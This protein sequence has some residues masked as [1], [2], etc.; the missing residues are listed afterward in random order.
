MARGKYRKKKLVAKKTQE[1]VLTSEQLYELP[2][3]TIPDYCFTEEAVCGKIDMVTHRCIPWNDPESHVRMDNP[4]FY[5]CSFSP[6]LILEKVDKRFTTVTGRRSR[7][8]RSG[9]VS[10]QTSGR[11]KGGNCV[12]SPI[13]RYCAMSSRAYKHPEYEAV[14][15]S[16]DKR[17]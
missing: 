1:I 10:S 12:A 16:I 15:K 9:K 8:K 14:M 3:N 17:K 5:G 4:L 7:K 13:Q 6:T 2:G 11:T